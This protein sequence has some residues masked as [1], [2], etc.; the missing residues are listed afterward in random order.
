DVEL[1]AQKSDSENKEGIYLVGVGVGDGVNDTLMDAVTDAG[2]GAYLY[3]DSAEEAQRM[4]GQRF[5]E[6]VEVGA[7]NVQVKA[8]LPWYM[9]MR[10]FY[11]EE[12]STDPYRVKPQHLAPGDS[13]VISQV[14]A[15]CQGAPVADADPIEVLAKWVEPLTYAR[16]SA[17]FTSTLGELKA[18]SRAELARGKAIIAYAEWLKRYSSAGADRVAGARNVLALAA[19]ADVT[20]TDAAFAEIREL[21]GRLE[22]TA[23]AVPSVEP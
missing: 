4:L 17:T 1:I 8:R 11:G 7:R 23:F 12:Y 22:P 18:N 19:A 6:S 9:S 2:N 16:K 5:A 15:S 13:M 10:R 21:V 3:L 20:G 14:L